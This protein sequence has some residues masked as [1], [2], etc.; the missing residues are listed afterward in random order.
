MDVYDKIYYFIKNN[1][2][3]TEEVLLDYLEKRIDEE[4][5]DN[6]V[7]CITLDKSR[8]NGY[9]PS[10]NSININPNEI[11]FPNV[12]KKMP[13]IN[14][15]LCKR[16][17]RSYKIKN[18]NTVNVYNL[19]SINHELNHASQKS[20]I[21]SKNNDLKKAFI[22]KDVLLTMYDICYFKS[23]YYKKYHDYFYKE[24][25]ANISSYIT[26]INMLN[27]YN[28][29][30]INKLLIE[31]NNIIAKHI[32]HLYKDLDNDHKYTTPVCNMKKLY[33]HIVKTALNH[34]VDLTDGYN[35][36]GFNFSKPNSNID[37]LKLGINIDKDTYNYIKNVSDNKEKTLNLF[38]EIN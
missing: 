35:F 37:K 9:N 19:M 14:W 6:F 22:I 11:L 27:N 20:I 16:E 18:P 24:Y 2:F 29:K 10:E 33:D 4:K 17:K 1:K 8:D 28:L 21:E 25:D 23:F 38:K 15:L 5:L 3:I 7:T 36:N 30:S 31:S 26:V 12:D 34:N 32:I 13:D